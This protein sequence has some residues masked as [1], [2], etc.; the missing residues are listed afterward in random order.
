MAAK[1]SCNIEYETLVTMIPFVMDFLDLEYQDIVASGILNDDRLDDASI[2]LILSHEKARNEEEKVTNPSQSANHDDGHVILLG[3]TESSKEIEPNQEAL[4][5]VLCT[6]EL[7]TVP[8]DTFRTRF[9]MTLSTFEALVQD[10]LKLGLTSDMEKTSMETGGALSLVDMLMLTLQFLGCRLPMNQL[11]AAASFDIAEAVYS[12]VVHETMEALYKLLPHYILWPDSNQVSEICATFKQ[13]SGLLGVLGTIDV[14]HVP[15]KAPA[16]HADYYTN[17]ENETTMV[18]QSVCDHR[19]RFIHSCTGWP[20]S[21]NEDT[22]LNDS[23]LSSDIGEQISN[24]PFDL[25]LV[26]D[27][28]YSL[29]PWLMTPFADYGHLCTLQ[30]Q[31][32]SACRQV[33]QD[34]TLVYSLLI[35]RFPRLEYVEMKDMQSTV[36]AV[37]V[38]CALHNFCLDNED[39]EVYDE[40]PVMVRNINSSVPDDDDGSLSEELQEGESKRQHVLQRLQ[41]S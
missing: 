32:N 3:E 19:M 23:D 28:A 5:Y 33:L 4:P 18:L 21:V 22:I 14:L 24:F 13:R 29:K 36:E 8:V 15:V 11:A 17:Q 9:R 10:L 31:F 34:N 7:N 30:Q 27:E 6:S 41:E 39:Q 40:D 38:C 25:Y 2:A 16:E 35:Q 26:G 1:E 20:G 12:S 37:L